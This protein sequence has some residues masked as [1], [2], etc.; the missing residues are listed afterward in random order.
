MDVIGVVDDDKCT[1]M[2]RPTA[3]RQQLSGNLDGAM[4][5][6]GTGAATA[7]FNLP[8]PESG[9]VIEYSPC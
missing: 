6:T 3:D 4:V 1:Q 9:L 8:I 7:E 2:I 5:G